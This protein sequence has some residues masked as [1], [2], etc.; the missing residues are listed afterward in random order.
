MR[1][2]ADLDN[3]SYCRGETKTRQDW[4]KS[5]GSKELGGGVT[6]GDVPC[7][8]L[9]YLPTFVRVLKSEYHVESCRI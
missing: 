3:G 9:V 7:V 1:A 5:L 8:K 6:H 4:L 2:F